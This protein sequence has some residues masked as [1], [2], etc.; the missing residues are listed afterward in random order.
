MRAHVSLRPPR[1]ARPSPVSARSISHG[2]LPSTASNP[3]SGRGSPS[4]R[5]TLRGTATPS[6]RRLQRRSRPPRPCPRAARGLAR[7]A[8]CGL[9]R[10]AAAVPRRVRADI[11]IAPEQPARTRGRRP[12]SNAPP[13]CLSGAAVARAGVPCRALAAAVTEGASDRRSRSGHDTA[14]GLERVL[15]EQRELPIVAWRP[16]RA[17]EAHPRDPRVARR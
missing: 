14:P 7:P 10:R 2:G 16:A 3:A 9:R 4:S 17:P 5:G 1:A 15:A 11:A 6:A 8:P 13:H 12:A